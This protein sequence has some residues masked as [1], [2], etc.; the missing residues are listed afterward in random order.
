MNNH[1]SGTIPQS[2]VG[3]RALEVAWLHKNGLS[4]TVPADF[5]NL[6]L[7]SLQL[8]L[9]ELSGGLPSFDIGVGNGSS[10]PLQQHLRSIEMSK[11]AFTGEEHDFSS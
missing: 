7:T 11:N 1:L 10:S 4:G 9:N 3:W 2:I 6:K 5:A 8:A